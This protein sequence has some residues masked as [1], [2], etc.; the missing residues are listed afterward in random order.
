MRERTP[1]RRSLLA[2]LPRLELLVTTGMGNAAIDV[3][4]AREQGVT[5]PDQGVADSA[6]AAELTWALI[7]GKL[8]RHIHEVEDAAVRAGGWQQAI[9]PELYGRTLGDVGLGR[10]GTRAWPAT[11]P[12]SG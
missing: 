2:R 7:L 3:G 9:G 6:S 12:P 11:A 4:A 1:L 10:Q 5:V 8:V